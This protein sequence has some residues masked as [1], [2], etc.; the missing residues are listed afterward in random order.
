[1]RPNNTPGTANERN[2]LKIDEGEKELRK[3]I[4]SLIENVERREQLIASSMSYRLI[5]STAIAK[6]YMKK[7]DGE[8]DSQFS[9][10]VK[11]LL[12]D[13][14]LLKSVSRILCLKIKE[15]E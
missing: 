5:S 1:M 13:K 2:R 14:G 10:R 4:E 15:Q 3:Y 12:R 6:S 9:G 11:D 7:K 8:E